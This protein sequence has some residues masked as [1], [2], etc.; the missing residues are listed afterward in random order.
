[1]RT[2]QVAS[3]KFVVRALGNGLKL[4]ALMSDP[5]ELETCTPRCT[6]GKSLFVI[7]TLLFTPAVKS[8][9]TPKVSPLKTLDAITEGGNGGGRTKGANRSSTVYCASELTT[10]SPRLFEPNAVVDVVLLSLQPRMFTFL[11]S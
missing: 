6:L 4:F 2:P 1:M 5:V 10:P 3:A 7:V 8:A 9:R 11:T